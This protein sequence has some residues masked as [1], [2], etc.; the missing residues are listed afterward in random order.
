MTQKKIL[1]GDIG[2]SH[3]TIGLFEKKETQLELLHTERSTIDS[4]LTED[5]IL[6]QWYSIF[7]QYIDTPNDFH[8]SLA[9]PAPFDYHKGICLIKDQG[10]FKN[11][12]G[13][14][15]KLKLS[16][17][18]GLPLS[19]IKFINDAEAFLQ[20]E[21]LFGKGTGFSSLL[22]LTLGSG[23]G[24]AFKKGKRVVDAELWS[25]PFKEGMV[26]DYLGTIWFTKWAEKKFDK[27]LS[28]VK[29]ILDNEGFINEI[30][31][32][33]KIYA[34][35]LSEFLVREWHKHHFEAVVIGGNIS[36]SAHLFK[37]QVMENLQI[38]GIDIPIRISDLGELS[39]LYGASSLYID[40]NSLRVTG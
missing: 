9:M 37:D 4:S 8:I 19:R 31:P 22:G 27:K 17:E 39:A 11:L 24:S 16:K 29:E 34:E 1:A 7:K 12:Y 30:V 5:E 35:N 28:G 32:L 38:A 40:S 10:K 15:L 6:A 2:G 21:A 3:L 14:N 25:S 26:E 20:G 18:L 33:F 23:L 36:L 13:V